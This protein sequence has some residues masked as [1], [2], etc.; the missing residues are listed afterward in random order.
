MTHVWSMSFH[1]FLLL[2]LASLTPDPPGRRSRPAP[3]DSKAPPKSGPRHRGSAPGTSCLA[4]CPL[5]LVHPAPPPSFHFCLSLS[6][7]MAGAPGP[8]PEAPPPPPHL[9]SAFVFPNLQASPS[10]S[11][12]QGSPHM[13]SRPQR[14]QVKLNIFS[15][16]NS[17]P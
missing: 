16:G 4:L 9:S 5:P 1:Q 12:S 15:P 3:L 13:P 10:C 7:T 2:R 17:T 14:S 11:L 8:I 6:L